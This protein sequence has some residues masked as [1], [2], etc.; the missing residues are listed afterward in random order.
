MTD[1]GD[2]YDLEFFGRPDEAA[3]D[4]MREIYADGQGQ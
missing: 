3:L 4:R 2:P 1:D